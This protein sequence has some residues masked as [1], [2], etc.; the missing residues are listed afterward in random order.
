MP[1]KMSRLTRTV[2]FSSTALVLI[3]GGLASY[4]YRH[5]RNR[6]SLSDELFKTCVQLSVIGVV[7]AAIPELYRRLQSERD[8]KQSIRDLDAEACKDYMQRLG[9]HY[10]SAKAIRRVLKSSGITKPASFLSADLVECYESAMRD[11]DETQLELEALKIEAEARPEFARIKGLK[12]N[13]FEM[14]DYLR[15]VLQEYEK[16]RPAFHQKSVVHFV[17]F[18][19]LQEFCAGNEQF[20]ERFSRRYADSIQLI[21]SHLFQI[22]DPEC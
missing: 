22:F 12:D 14:E 13:L 16:H 7:G 2:A 6:E 5:S 10:R 18:S 19:R 17:A 20:H 8:R 9:S 3:A 1:L 11:L 4:L 21:S 15:C